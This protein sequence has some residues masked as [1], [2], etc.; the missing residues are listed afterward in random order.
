MKILIY[1]NK[2]KDLNGQWLKEFVDLLNQKK[3]EYRILEDCNLKESENADA[4]FVHGGDGTILFLTE[5]ASRNNI[6]LIGIN[7]GKLGFLTEFEY[8]ES[9][10]ALELLLGGELIKDERETMHIRCKDKDYFALNDV[11]FQRI[12]HESNGMLV[13][14]D[15]NIDENKVAKFKGD[16][17]VIS[18]P[19]GSTAYSLS[20]G[21]PVLAPRMNAF[22]ISP[23]AA[24]SLN[25]KPIV[26]SSDST[27]TVFVQGKTSTGL[28]VDGT[29]VDK[30]NKG[31]FITVTKNT[32]RVVFLRKK[33]F[34][35]YNRLNKKLHNSLD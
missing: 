14:V 30:L 32:N 27:C 20:A 7:A 13:S 33:T 26:Y 16:G 19:T 34:N 31:E 29:Y 21:G 10:I 17:V 18:T 35:F 1:D 5:F 2:G 9:K 25:T 15:V 23:I 12:Y 22:V 4:L 3:I 28:F 8:N 11:F 6:P 24:H